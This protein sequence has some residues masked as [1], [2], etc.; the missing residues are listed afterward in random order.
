MTEI[1][2]VPS[3]LPILPELILAIGAMILLMFG[4]ARGERATCGVGGLAIVI[5]IV[6][7]VALLAQPAD[8]IAI[9]HGSFVLDGFARFLKILALLGSAFAI[10]LSRSEERRVGKECRSGGAQDH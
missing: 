8:K 4:V 10:V 3:L 7:G 9:F 1:L 2:D 5:L 6:A